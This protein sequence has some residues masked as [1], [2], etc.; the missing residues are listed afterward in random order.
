MVAFIAETEVMPVLSPLITDVRLFPNVDGV[1]V[2][3]P[4]LVSA[5]LGPETRFTP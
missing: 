4:A 1:G 3:K 5:V 2:E